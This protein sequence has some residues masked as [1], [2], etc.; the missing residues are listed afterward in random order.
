MKVKSDLMVFGLILMSVFN[1]A[2][3][4]DDEMLKCDVKVVS[5]VKLGKPVELTFKLTN[6]SAK[7]LW[8]LKWNT[9]LEGWFGSAFNVTRDGSS[10]NYIG[11]MVK[12]WKPSEADY[13]QLAPN[14]SIENTVD[15]AQG[16]DL[17]TAGHYKFVFNGRIQDV[18]QLAKG[19]VLSKRRKMHTLTC[20]DLLVKIKP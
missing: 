10:V 20:D 2:Q 5:Q 1:T 6:T 4:G 15:L 11:A 16:Y 3:A 7:P 18:Q 9:P 19:E 12:R 14:Q 17:K 13:S 8:I